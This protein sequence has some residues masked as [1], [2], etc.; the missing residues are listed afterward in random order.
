MRIAAVVGSLKRILDE[1]VRA[2][3][4]AVTRAIRA[5][6]ERLK[7]ELR[8]QVVSAFGARGRGLSGAWR[9]RVFP[10]SGDSLG[11]AGIVWT[12]APTIIDAF[13]RGAVIRARGARYLAV[14]TGFNAARGRRGRGAQGVRVTPQQMVASGQAFVRP[15]RSGRGFVWC[16]PVR[17][18]DRIG[19]RRAPLIAGGFAAVATANRRGA[20]R[21]QAEL[22]R[23]GFV[24]MFLL[25]PQVSLAR[26]LNAREAG[27]RA[28]ARLPA[29]VA[30][31]WRAQGRTA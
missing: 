16:L 28:L 15:F 18:G 11:A 2:G 7:R 30:A 10:Q 1:E 13:E 24:P 3:E 4:R 20:A 9:S 29:A 31:E 19:R 6:T 12:K 26:R 21:W 5:E 17:Q 14:P 23:Q 27:R 22:L 8:E 25:L